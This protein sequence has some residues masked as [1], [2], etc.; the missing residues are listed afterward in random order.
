[1]K[2]SSKEEIRNARRKSQKQNNEM[3]LDTLSSYSKSRR[4]G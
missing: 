3:L 1:M 2:N 4:E